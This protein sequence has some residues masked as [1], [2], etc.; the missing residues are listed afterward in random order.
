M[1]CDM[2][3]NNVYEVFSELGHGGVVHV[4]LH[5]KILESFFIISVLTNTGTLTTGLYTACHI[6]WLYT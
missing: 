4:G 5:Q 2:L 3:K 6:L 1:A